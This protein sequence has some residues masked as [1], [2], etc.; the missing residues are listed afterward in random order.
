M[1]GLVAVRSIQV[2]GLAFQ[3]DQPSQRAPKAL[4]RARQRI[5]RLDVGRG[6]E[7]GL[8]LVLKL[9]PKCANLRNFL[10]VPQ[11]DG[12]AKLSIFSDDS[13]IIVRSVLRSIV[14]A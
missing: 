7:E 8:R 9:V 12:D 11:Y 2:E 5:D 13:R 4:Y 10:P 14:T 3:R 1:R 6:F